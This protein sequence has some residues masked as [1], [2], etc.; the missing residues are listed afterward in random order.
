VPCCRRLWLPPALRLSPDQE[1]ERLYLLYKV[2]QLVEFGREALGGWGGGDPPP[3]LE[4]RVRSGADLLRLEV[5]PSSVEG[6]EG[7]LG[8][9]L[10]Y[11][12]V[13]MKQDLVRELLALLR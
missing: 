13:E 4:G 1:W 7:R 9:V 11:V 3:C 12:V 5:Q 8:E 2:R 10:Q 6:G